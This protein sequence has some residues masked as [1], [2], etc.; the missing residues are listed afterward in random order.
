VTYADTGQ[1]HEGTIYKATNWAE[2]GETV[3]TRVWRD[4]TGKMV[5]QKAKKTRT[6]AEM[7]EAGL[8]EEWSSKKRFYKVLSAPTS[9][10]LR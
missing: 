7:R 4:L 5:A 10:E 6:L 8:V 2:A 9:C 1:G 3:P